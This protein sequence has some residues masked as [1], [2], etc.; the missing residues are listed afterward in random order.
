[1]SYDLDNAIERLG[2][3]AE[4]ELTDAGLEV[5]DVRTAVRI[6]AEVSIAL[7]EGWDHEGLYGNDSITIVREVEV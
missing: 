4:D 3:S 6:T 7:P 2:S 5:S 1:M